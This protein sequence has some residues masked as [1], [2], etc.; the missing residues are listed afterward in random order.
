[1]RQMQSYMLKINNNEENMTIKLNVMDRV[2]YSEPGEPD[3][4]GCIRGII[5]DNMVLVNFDQNYGDIN[6]RVFL[7]KQLKREEN[8][9]QKK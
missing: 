5:N 4:R 2:I 9:V 8:E 1:M 7:M 6:N 3:K